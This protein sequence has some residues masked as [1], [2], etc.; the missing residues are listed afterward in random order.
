M[1]EATVHAHQAGSRKLFLY[2]WFWLLALTGVEVYL[3]YVQ[4]GVKLMLT[5]LMGLSIVKA[6]LIISYFMHLRFERRSLVLTLM[7]AMV[8]VIVLLFLFFPDSLRLLHMRP[9]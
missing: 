1:S 5:L 4:L 8:F 2:V 7:P 6:T 9:Q 3:S